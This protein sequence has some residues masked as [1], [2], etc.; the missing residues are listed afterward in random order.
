[1]AIEVSKTTTVKL[2]RK[3]NEVH[4][5]QPHKLSSVLAVLAIEEYC[6]SVFVFLAPYIATAV[7]TVDLRHNI[8]G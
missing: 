2:S 6:C 3:T 4:S 8:K 5:Q 1:M 7:K